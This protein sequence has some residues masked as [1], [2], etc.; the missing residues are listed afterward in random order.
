[1]LFRSE[2]GYLRDTT[3]N[4]RF[5]PVHAPGGGSKN[6]WELTEADVA[7]VWAE[8]KYLYE[9]GER[10]L[11]DDEI[12]ALAKAAQREAMETDDRE[13]IVLEYLDK[14]LPTDWSKMDLNARRGFLRND[15]FNGGDK[16]GNVQRKTV[17]VMEIWAECFCREPGAIKKTDRGE[18]LSI[19]AK[20]GWKNG[21]STTQRTAYGVQKCFSRPGIDAD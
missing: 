20:L 4:R 8:A 11:L 7:Q 15:P 3:G 21:A 17:C 5:W 2:Q 13:G 9:Q 19:L 12:E 1:M 16:V 14:L 6:S 18:I 10:P